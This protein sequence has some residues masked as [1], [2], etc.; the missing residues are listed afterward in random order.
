MAHARLPALFLMEMAR[1]VIERQL[2]HSDKNEIRAA[3]NRAEYM[4]ERHTMMIWWADYLDRAE[5]GKGNVIEG[6]FGINRAD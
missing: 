1:D 3:Y 4:P 5:N 2:A 6:K